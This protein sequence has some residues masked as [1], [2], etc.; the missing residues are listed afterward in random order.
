YLKENLQLRYS[1]CRH[2]QIGWM[3]LKVF[4]DGHDFEMVNPLVCQQYVGHLADLAKIRKLSSKEIRS[5]KAATV[6]SEFITT[7]MIEQRRAYKFLEG[8]IGLLIQRY[9]LSK[10]SH[11]LRNITIRQNERNLS[12]FNFWLTMEHVGEIDQLRHEHIVR[13]IQSLDSSKPGN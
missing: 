11:R 4:M 6:L 2:Y 9:I 8:N 5:I 12:R 13:F 3:Q 7:G 1:S 10:A